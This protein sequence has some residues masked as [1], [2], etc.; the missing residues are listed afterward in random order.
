MRWTKGRRSEQL[1]DRRGQAPARA[2]VSGGG[3]SI[4][5]FLF[6]KFGF[7]GLL[8]G[9][10][11]L[12][13]L[14]GFGTGESSSLSAGVPGESGSRDAQ[15]EPAVQFVSFVLDD[16]QQ[17]WLSLLQPTETPYRLARLVLFRGETHSGCGL[18]QAEMGPFYCSRDEKVYLDLGFFDDLRERFRAAGDF[19]QA[20]VIAHEIGHHVQHIVGTLERRGKGKQQGADGLSVRMELQADCYAGVWAHSAAERDILEP[21]D[22]EE[23]L[24]A[25]TAIGDD[26]LQRT[27]AGSVRP[28]TFTHGTSEQRARW[29]R[30][31]FEGGDPQ[32]CDTFA[33]ARL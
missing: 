7:V 31:G 23:A 16:A 6:R 15:E 5:L 12:Y 26:A 19:A 29:F 14:G 32:K 24:R 18:G 33:A 22:L 2:G 27:A 20:Y 9:A 10:A 8:A 17:A 30:R 25:A 11:A 13:F 4:L 28:E 3:A 1:E 21:G